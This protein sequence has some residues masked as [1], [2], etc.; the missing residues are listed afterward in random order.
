MQELKDIHDDAISAMV[1]VKIGSS[2]S[3]LW[4]GSWDKSLSVISAPFKFEESEET[5]EDST[6]PMGSM[7]YTGS[8][9]QRK[10]SKKSIFTIGK[11]TNSNPG[12]A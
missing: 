2:L 5:T 3:E 4:I 8:L 6:I 1:S 9:Q 11:Y 10:K 7:Q 12:K